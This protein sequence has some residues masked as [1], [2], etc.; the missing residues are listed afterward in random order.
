M[1]KLVQAAK[2]R[3]ALRKART[4]KQAKVSA[5]AKATSKGF[6]HF[7]HTRDSLQMLSKERSDIRKV[8]V[9]LVCP[10][11]SSSQD[12]RSIEFEIIATKEQEGE[13]EVN[14]G[15]TLTPTG[16]AGCKMVDTGSE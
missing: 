4:G 5:K 15:D 9:N 1:L 10:E 16:T 13:K 2:A 14:S 3:L 11:G 7:R 8:T 6:F 12:G